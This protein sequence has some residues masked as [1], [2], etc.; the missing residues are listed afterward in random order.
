[1]FVYI[2]IIFITKEFFKVTKESWPEPICTYISVCLY[3]K[4]SSQK[5]HVL[6]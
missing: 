2:Y 3:I 6:Q 4:I 1:M 5:R